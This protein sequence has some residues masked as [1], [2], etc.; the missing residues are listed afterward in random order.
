MS[1]EPEEVLP[2][3]RLATAGRIEEMAAEPSVDEK[4]DQRRRERGV[5]A[6][7]EDARDQSH[8][9]EER[10]AR[11]SHARAAHQQDRHGQI[12]GADD[13]AGAVHRETDDVVIDAR[14]GREG[15]LGERGV[16]EPSGVGGASGEEAEIE[17]DPT[18]ER[19]PE[20]QGVETRERDV[21]RADHQRYEVVRETHEKWD[22]RKQ[23]HRDAVHGESLIE[24][25]GIEK[26]FFRCGQLR[27]Q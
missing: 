26:A 15:S 21:A 4:H 14:A 5:G 2:Q 18:R 9:D 1:E 23:D 20:G 7:N 22:D 16:R 27:T 11:D 25:F 12:D 13:R 19:Q 10:D 17:H 6:E 8:P 24:G 3:H